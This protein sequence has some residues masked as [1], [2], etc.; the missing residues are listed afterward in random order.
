MQAIL[1]NSQHHPVLCGDKLGEG[2]EGVVYALKGDVTRVVKRYHR[3]LPAPQAA[4]LRAALALRNPALDAVCAWPQDLLH[5]ARGALYGFVMPRVEAFRELHALY[6]PADRRQYFENAGFDFLVQAARNLAAAVGRVHEHGLVIGDL[7]PRNVM[8]NHQALVRLIDCDSMQLTAA[9]STH[10]CLVSTPHLTPPELQGVNFAEVD[11]SPL[12]DSFALAILLFHLLMMGRHPYAGVYAGE[13]EMSLE[14]AIREGRY[15][16][17]TDAG[18][19]YQMSAPP[20][21][22]PLG[23]LGAGLAGLFERAFTAV[24]QARPLPAEWVQALDR[25]QSGLRP[26]AHE[27]RHRFHATQ[28]RCP[29]CVLEEQGA[30]YF[31]PSRDRKEQPF[32]PEHVRRSLALV[33]PPRFVEPLMHD[34]ERTQPDPLIE[35]LGVIRLRLWILG[36]LGALVVLVLLTTPW[37][38]MG[39]A[40]GWP[41]GWWCRQQLRA[42]ER[43]GV[44]RQ[45]ALAAAQAELDSALQELG[46][47]QFRAQ[48]EAVRKQLLDALQRPEQLAAAF[49]AELAQLQTRNRELQLDEFLRRFTLRDA[50]ITQL[51]L[52][53]RV[54]LAAHGMENA[55]DVTPERL[56]AVRGIDGSLQRSLYLW[57]DALSR[58]FSFNAASGVPR[59]DLERL[60][61]RFRR[62]RDEL[63]ME[64]RAS[65]S[66]LKRHGEALL[67]E[68][69]RRLSGLRPLV[70]K[71][72]QARANLGM[73]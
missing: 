5:D 70:T 52:E 9:G 21:V 43:I 73:R 32:D 7:N 15:A 42:I 45:A 39:L 3:A 22:P 17:A 71:V 2:G 41:L 55:A 37:W 10:R 1:L 48:F 56:R 40:L 67:A 34:N 57:R 8:V 60:N 44:Q 38:W 29:W 33:A 64:L 62:Q 6:S 31:V 63:I 18:A 58:K 54:R 46:V 30:F 65:P 14:R 27:P 24:P 20:Q 28:L 66:Q 50:H 11:R 61:A 53:H 59:A 51:T 35:D 49:R 69:Q 26:C 25:L 12:H 72:H 19:R 4:K 16:Y 47:G 36:G 13:G 23:V 68:Q